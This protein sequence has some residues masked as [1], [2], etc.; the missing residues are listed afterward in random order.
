MDGSGEQVRPTPAGKRCSLNKKRSCLAI[1]GGPLRGPEFK[2]ELIGHLHVC[3]FFY[4]F[5]FTDDPKTLD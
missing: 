3:C 2:S 5:Y 1:Q 4:L